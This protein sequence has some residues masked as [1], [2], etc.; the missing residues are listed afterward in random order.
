MKILREVGK[1]VREGEVVES[2][3]AFGMIGLSRVSSRSV[4]LFGSAVKHD[5][6]LELTIKGATRHTSIWKDWYF[7]REELI[8]VSIS[9]TQLGELLSSM[10]V[11]D[12]VPCTITR[13]NGEGMPR[14]EEFSTVQEEAQAQMDEQL[15]SLL[16]ASKELLERAQTIVKAGA[17]RK[18]D[19]EELLSLLTQLSHGIGENIN[20]AS[21][22]FE[23]KMEKTIM[24]AKG[25][26][27]T[28]INSKIQAAGLAA[29]QGKP[30]VEIE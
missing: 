8:R 17:P 6:F 7:G 27:E 10:N 24:Q 19:K 26:V 21:K 30:L 1:G 20:Y 18:A 9:G 22:C 13:F 2:H 15:S 5:H 11:G 23:E 12:G 28:F 29:L 16:K 4:V 25:E 14:I 3:P